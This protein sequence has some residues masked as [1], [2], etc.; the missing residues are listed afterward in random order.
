MKH[1]PAA[2]PS[3]EADSKMGRTVRA[4]GLVLAALVIVG[5]LGGVAGAKGPS[6]LTLKTAKGELTVGQ[7]VVA[8]STNLIF[9][10]SSGNLECSSN[11]L[12][13]KL[14]K[15]NS[16]KDEGPIE[17]ES[18]TGNEPGGLC[19]TTTPLGATEI[20]TS[21][22]PWLTVLTSK[23]VDEVKG[24]KVSFTSVFPDRRCD[25][26]VRSREGQEH[27]HARRA[28]HDR[29]QQTEVQA[30]QEDQHGGLPQGRH[31]QRDLHRDV[32]RRNRRIGTDLRPNPDARDDEV[33]KTFSRSR[34]GVPRR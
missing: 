21:N 29:D 7:E 23:G 14:A 33:N 13:G 16:K 17:S 25:L 30:Q 15:N 32:R 8:D 27:L 18:S 26:R 3:K 22:L 9:E 10:T 6:L 12:K 28:G 19:K 24:K 11:I 34:R 1:R 20:K 5:L 2:R 4:A 31:P